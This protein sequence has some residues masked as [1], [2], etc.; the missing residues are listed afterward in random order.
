MGRVPRVSGRLT[1]GDRWGAF[2]A[3]WGVGRMN[4]TV[5]PGLYAVGDPDT[6]SPVL[7]TAN[8]KLSFDH[9]RGCLVGRSC[10]ILALDTDGINVWCAAGKGT[11]GTKELVQRIESSRIAE[12][13][14]HRRLIL[15]QLAGPGVAAHEVKRL[16]GLR[17]V[18]GPIRAEDI[19]RFLDDGLKATQA[20]RRKSFDLAE[21]TVLIPVELVEALRYGLLLTPALLLLGGIS[22]RGAF[23]ANVLH[24]GAF[25]VMGLMVSIVAG[26]VLFP[27]LLPWLPGRA[28]SLKGL[29]LGL[30][31]AGILALFRH[32][33]WGNWP[34]R[35]EIL[36]WCL[37]V[38]AITTYLAMNFT[39]ASTYTSLSG[40][41]KEMRVAVPLQIGG[42]VVGLV[43]WVA[44]GL[45]GW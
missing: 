10:W 8:Y 29:P 43:L 11:F 23:W 34:G 21:R 14:S 45:I 39:G 1:R 44:R 9:L 2:K 22:G 35:L 3:R 38:P 24:Q 36:A 7:V 27:V 31:A 19:P 6:E 30:V 26:A 12:V 40:V 13:V 17:V 4:Y 16:S 5:E 37:M 15:P 25:A 42:L 20:M 32:D 18:Y 28:F 41:K 33:A